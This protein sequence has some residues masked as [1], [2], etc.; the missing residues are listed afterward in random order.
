MYFFEELSRNPVLGSKENHLF[1]KFRAVKYTGLPE[2]DQDG[3][4]TNLAP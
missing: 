4:R 2:V 3:L 1:P